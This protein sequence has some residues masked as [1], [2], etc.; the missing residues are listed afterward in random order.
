VIYLHGAYAA[1]P[2]FQYLQQR[3]LALHAKRHGFTLLLPTAPRTEGGYLWPTSQ[4]AQAR[5]EAGVLDGIRRSKAELER[6]AGKRFDET[7]VIGF[8]TGAYYASTLALRSALDVDGY[9]VLAGGASWARPEG[10]A[11]ATR[12]PVFVGVSAADKATASHSRAFG[13]TLA[14]LGWPRRVEERNAG[15]EVDWTFVAH[16]IGWL[17]A[18]S[19][20][21]AGSLANTSLHD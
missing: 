2:G 7:F 21:R 17:R 4:A 6:R 15:H 18:Q 9:I 12:A 14:S 8:S 3:G 16:G 20:A 13:A 5:E 19:P 10:A 1:T 11:T